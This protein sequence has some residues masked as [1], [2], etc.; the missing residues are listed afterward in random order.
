[1]GARKICRSD[2]ILAQERS[3]GDVRSEQRAA[4]R[5]FSIF[6]RQGDK[7]KSVNTSIA[8]IV[9]LKTIKLDRIRAH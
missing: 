3:L 7:Y 5:F 9:N 2:L 4:T 8:Y 1:M 6:H